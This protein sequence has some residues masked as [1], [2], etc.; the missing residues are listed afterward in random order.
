MT[1]DEQREDVGIRLGRD[2]MASWKMW[3]WS[4]LVEEAVPS[5][6]R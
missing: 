3:N 6:P 5:A 4:G 1:E 2:S